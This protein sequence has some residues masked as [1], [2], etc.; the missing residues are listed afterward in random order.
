MR[1]SEENRKEALDEEEVQLEKH[2]MLAL[3]LSGILTIG[4]PCLLLILLIVG[5]TYL[6]F[7]GFH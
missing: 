1:T 4:I 6:L 7:G 5:V 2:D 3:W